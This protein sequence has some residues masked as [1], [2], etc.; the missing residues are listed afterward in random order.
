MTWNMDYWRRNESLRQIAW[1]FLENSK[2]DIALLQES[3]PTGHGKSIVFQE[4][5]IIDSRK[6]E[7][8][9]LG[10]GSSIVSFGPPIKEIDN[11]SSPFSQTPAPLTR[12]FPGSVAIG[13]I[14]IEKPII[15]ISMYGLIDRGYAETTVHRILSDLTPL[16]D[17]RNGKRIIIAGD[18]NITTQWSS[19]HKSFLRGRHEECLKRDRNLFERF[20]ILGFKNVVKNKDNKPL[21]DCECND[22]INCRHVQTQRHSHS[23]FPWQND[24]IFLS[25]DLRK[26]DYQ[27]HVIDQEE[28]W[29]LSNHCPIIIEFNTINKTLPTTNAKIMRTEK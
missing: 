2:I 17:R 24:Y 23:K 11:S 28:I 16:I 14:Q 10:W 22:G 29:K 21:K 8:R 26:L 20:E 13:E 18:L 19:K 15:V 12:T 9:Y 27:V 7:P 6:G 3:R 4:S 1:D 5:G 25:E